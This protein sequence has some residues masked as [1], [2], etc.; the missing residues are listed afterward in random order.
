MCCLLGNTCAWSARTRILSFFPHNNIK[1]STRMPGGC[2]CHGDG[3]FGAQPVPVLGTGLREWTLCSGSL[4]VTSS[5]SEERRKG[6]TWAR[7]YVAVTHVT[8]SPRWCHEFGQDEV[9][10]WCGSTEKAEGWAHGRRRLDDINLEPF[11]T[12]FQPWAHQ[13]H[14]KG[15]H[16]TS[17]SRRHFHTMNH[18]SSFLWKKQRLEAI[19]MIA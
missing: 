4:P 16:N 19:Q 9:G 6:S 2:S 10:I 8:F 3:L 13:K 1:K 12:A 14:S 7:R 17:Q 18:N 5:P 15:H 11:H